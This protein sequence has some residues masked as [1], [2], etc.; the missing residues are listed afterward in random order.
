MILCLIIYVQL[1]NYGQVLNPAEL[2]KLLVT[3]VNCRI[4]F[5]RKP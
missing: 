2:V 3:L 5:W 4:I 1:F